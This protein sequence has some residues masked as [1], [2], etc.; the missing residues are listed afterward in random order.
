MTGIRDFSGCVAVVTG[1][2]SGIGKAL[3]ARLVAEG[4]AAVIAD[5]DADL[6]AATAEDIGATPYVVDVRDAAVQ[7]LADWTVGEFGRADLVA[8]NAGVGPFAP[9][10]ELTLDGFRSVLDIDVQVAGPGMRLFGVQVRR[11]RPD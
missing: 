5:N 1:G 3:T 4:A 11:R 6:L 2:A 9:F 10:D 8:N 7:Q